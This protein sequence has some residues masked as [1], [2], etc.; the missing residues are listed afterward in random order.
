MKKRGQIEMSFGMIFSIIMIVI[1]ISFAF[2]A[3]SKFLDVQNST[4]V[5]SFVTDFQA[6]IDKI[7][8]GSQGMQEKTYSLPEKITHV[9][10]I[11]YASS[12]RGQQQTFYHELEQNYYESEN[13]FFYP[14]GAAQG[15]NAKEMKNIALNKTVIDENPLCFENEEGK[16]TFIIKKEFGE[17]LVTISR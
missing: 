10:F 8:K 15:L 3:I 1:F 16:V 13:I 9:C 14:I 5:G 12:P 17:A 11:D 7:W 6:D 2:Y 4:S